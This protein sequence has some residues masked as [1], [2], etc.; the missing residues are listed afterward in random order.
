MMKKARP[1]PTKFCPRENVRLDLRLD[2]VPL[3]RME[4]R[5]RIPPR[6]LQQASSKLHQ[7]P[8]DTMMR[9]S[10]TNAAIV[11]TAKPYTDQSTILTTL[12]NIGYITVFLTFQQ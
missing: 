11:S 8:A 7:A 12:D 10:H 6:E 2:A 9:W 4:D 5:S 3:H 1:H